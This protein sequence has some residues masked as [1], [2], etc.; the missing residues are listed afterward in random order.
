MMS[1]RPRRVAV[2]VNDRFGPLTSK[3]AMALIRYGEGQVVAAVDRSKRPVDA[4]EYIGSVGKGIPVVDNIG[5]AMATRELLSDLRDLGTVTG[6]PPPFSKRDRSRFLQR[7]DEMI[8]SVRRR[9][10]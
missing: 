3:T 10:P 6:G 9:T 2:L 7:L 1:E 8:Q 4:S 5:D